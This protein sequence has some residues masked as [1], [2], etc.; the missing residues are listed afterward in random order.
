ASF[1]VLRNY[2][3][4]FNPE[5]IVEF[6][7]PVTAY[8]ALT[9]YNGIGETVALLFK[10]NAEKNT[11]FKRT[12]NGSHNASGMYYAELQYNGVTIIRKMLLLK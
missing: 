8:A 12:F 1:T 10:G 6:S 7:I 4:P 9:I 2:P 11:I 5:T 3:N